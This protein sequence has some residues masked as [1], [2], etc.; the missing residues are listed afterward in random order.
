[1]VVLIMLMLVLVCLWRG[2]WCLVGFLEV[3]AEA[4]EEE[5]RKKKRWGE[6]RAAT[7]VLVVARRWWRNEG[8]TRRKGTCRNMMLVGGCGYLLCV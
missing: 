8:G 6:R 2:S 3:D 1:M 5:G 7:A 4:E